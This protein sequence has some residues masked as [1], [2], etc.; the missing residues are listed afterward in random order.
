MKLTKIL[1]AALLLSSAVACDKSGDDSSPSTTVAIDATLATALEKQGFEIKNGELV[2][3]DKV[4]STTALNLS[5]A[6]LSTLDG[7]ENFTSLL[8]LDLTGNHFESI[9]DAD[10]RALTEA[11]IN[12]TAIDLE[13]NQLTS[14]EIGELESVETLCLGANP[15][16]VEISGLELESKL[17]LKS[18]LLPYSLR[19]NKAA[20]AY[21]AEKPHD[22]SMK[23]ETSEGG[24]EDFTS[25]REI[26]DDVFR[27][28][29][30]GKYPEVFTDSKYD[31][32]KEFDLSGEQEGVFV[33]PKHTWSNGD[34]AA[35]D[36]NFFD[37]SE[38]YSFEGLQYFKHL[39]R[40]W[41][42]YNLNVDSLDLSD[43]VMLRELCVGCCRADSYDFYPVPDDSFKH[44]N[45]DGCTKLSNFIA[46]GG[47]EELDL[48]TLDSLNYLTFGIH[49]KSVDLSHQEA[50]NSI[51]LNR[52]EG[53]F[54]D[55]AALEKLTLPKGAPLGISQIQIARSRVSELD[56]EGVTFNTETGVD[57]IVERCDYLKEFKFGSRL[58]GFTSLR[59][60]SFESIDLRG[61]TIYN[62]ATE[63]WIDASTVESIYAG[64]ENLKTLNGKPY[65]ESDY[66]KISVDASDLMM[67]TY[68]AFNAD[69]ELVVVDTDTYPEATSTESGADA[70][71]K[72]RDDWDLA[73]HNYD[74]RTNSGASGDAEGG[75]ALLDVEEIADVDKSALAEADYKADVAEQSMILSLE[76]MP[77]IATKVAM[78]EYK[79]FTMAGMPP[80]YIPE[81]KVY[82]L[83]LADGGYALLKFTN[84]YGGSDAKEGV[85]DI[86]YLH[87]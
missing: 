46:D 70:E 75:L 35:Y 32:N 2:V 44:I 65:G 38:I 19:E 62:D 76:S 15:D 50:I 40:T 24:I 26:P 11:N 72:V 3:D 34:F 74:L 81:P 87:N 33:S 4:K 25:L 67:W 28:F 22:V 8:A 6:G 59:N 51:Y 9:T 17:A 83:R 68:L 45:V 85:V 86:E 20:L 16:L 57:L 71:W 78:S 69:G 10:W 36:P 49:V 60:G 73:L 55:E 12:L 30:M 84:Y 13:Q 5:D 29:L 61:A 21:Y 48:S 66:A 43:A 80:A 31:L 79:S 27:E 1:F 56:L 54:D 82:A 41:Y 7:V 47:V 42:V 14:I 23:V 37:A 64:N 39:I 58:G 52:Y 53:N 18:I 77:P 63:E